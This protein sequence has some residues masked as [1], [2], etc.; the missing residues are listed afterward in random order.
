MNSINQTATTAIRRLFITAALAAVILAAFPVLVPNAGQVLAQ[1][2]QSR[3]PVLV[4]KSTGSAGP[5][6]MYTVPANKRLVIE[7]ITAH[8]TQV[9]KGGEIEL[10]LFVEF[11]DTSFYYY[12]PIPLQRLTFSTYDRFQAF[13]QGRI[14]VRSGIEVSIKVTK[15]N[16]TFG[17][18]E[19]ALAGYLEDAP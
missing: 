12:Q 15:I 3:E 10:T 18:A 8:S 19:V 13:L 7:T 4:T 6:H 11:P 2:E 17:G 16:T 9:S 5:T 14:Y 1:T